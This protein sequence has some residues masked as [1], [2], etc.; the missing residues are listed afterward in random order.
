D[1]PLEDERWKKRLLQTLRT[2]WYNL[3]LYFDNAVLQNTELTRTE[4]SD[5]T[6]V[7]VTRVEYYQQN[8]LII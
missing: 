5:H 7:I 3:Y 4:H 1:Q 6:W 8:R 2:V